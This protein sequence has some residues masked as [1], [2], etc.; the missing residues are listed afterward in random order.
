MSVGL[1][2]VTV[3]LLLLMTPYAVRL[4]RGPTV[5]DRIVAFNGVGTTVPVVLVIVGLMFE[6]PAMF[7]D[8]AIALFLLNLFMT[9]LV[10]KYV[11]EKKG[12]AE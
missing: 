7:V 11:R 2:A 5:F 8:L 10:A 1:A 4:I 6:R 9:L 3:I 12:A